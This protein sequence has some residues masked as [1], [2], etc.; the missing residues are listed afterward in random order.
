[1]FMAWIRDSMLYFF[2]INY[3]FSSK[4]LLYSSV[5]YAKI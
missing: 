3:F 2:K 1:M 5:S 4:V